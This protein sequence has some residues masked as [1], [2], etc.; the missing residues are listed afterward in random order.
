MNF[1]RRLEVEIFGFFAAFDCH[2]GKLRA[3]AIHMFA[4]L[5]VGMFRCGA[6]EGGF[7]EAS[8][9]VPFISLPGMSIAS[10]TSYITMADPSL[11]KASPSMIVVRTFEVPE[12]D[13]NLLTVRV[14]LL[15]DL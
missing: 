15:E 9:H 12:N 6:T 2:S 5:F 1:H 11:S 13:V 4:Y 7:S 8:N 14:F 3:Q 10:S